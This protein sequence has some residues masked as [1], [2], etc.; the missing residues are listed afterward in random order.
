M[1]QTSFSFFQNF[2]DHQIFSLWNSSRTLLDIAHNLGFEGTQLSR[3]DSEYIETRKT[4]DI[5][6]TYILSNNW[7][8]E[9]N[10]VQQIQHI[11]REEFESL[12]QCEGIQTVSHLALH[13]LLSSKH[14]RKQIKDQILRLQLSVLPRFQKG[15]FG[16]TQTPLYWPTRFYERRIAP[17]PLICPKCGFQ[18]THSS[19]IEFHHAGDRYHGPKKQRNKSYYTHEGIEPLCA[20]CHSL[21]HRTGEHLQQLCGKWLQ[22]K[23]PGNQKY[24]NPSHIFQENC[25]ETY[26]V[27]KQYYLKWILEGPHQYFCQNCGVS[28]WNGQVLSLEFHHRD[29][30]QQNSSLSNLQLLCPNCHRACP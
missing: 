23:P 8:L 4:R 6:Q 13:F 21:E 29:S 27:Q 10:R 20:N 3:Q 5:W 1:H 2:S 14:G 25:P 19:Q 24:T 12:F 15:V 28:T 22:N 18:A 9:W 11:S 16:H 26:R 17:K 30:N 7:A